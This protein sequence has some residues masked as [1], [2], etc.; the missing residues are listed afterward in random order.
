[1]MVRRGK[2]EYR[3]PE[4]PAPLG[5][6]LQLALG[7]DE[8]PEAFGD[9]VDAVA[10]LADRADIEVDLDMLCTTD[11]SPHRAAFDGRTQHYQCAFDPFIVPFLA[12]DVDAVEIETVAPDTG[13]PVSLTVTPDGVD[14]EPS[15]TVVSFGVAADVE[16]PPSDGASP[17]LAYERFCPYGHAF[18]DR[19]EYEA[20]AADVDAVTTAIGVPDALELAR[21]FGAAAD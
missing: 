12:D 16:G 15:G 8:R 5:D 3:G 19:E 21:A 7:L 14:V 17:V 11:D 10:R 1:M 20:W 13:A 9:W 18:P 2:T 4:L 6:R